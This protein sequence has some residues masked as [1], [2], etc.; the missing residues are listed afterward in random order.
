MRTE[1]LEYF[2]AITRL[3]SI[4]RASQ[5]LHVSQPALSETVR[6]LERELG[7][8][9]LDRHRAGAKISAAGR[10]LLPFITEALESVDRLREAADEQHRS[11]RMIRI[12][13]VSAATVPLLVPAVRDLHAAYPNTQIEI[14]N[15]QQ[16]DIQQWL[17]EG[18]LDVGLVNLIEGDDTDPDLDAT[19][20]LRGR[21]VLCCRTDSRFARLAAVTADD[22]R[23]EPL[24]VMRAGYVMHRYV[25]RLFGG[26]PPSIAY[27]ADGAEMGKLMVAEGLGVTLLPDYSV[28]GDPLE[29]AGVITSRPVEP[30]DVTVILVMQRRRDNRLAPAIRELQELLVSHVSKAALTGSPAA[31]MEPVRR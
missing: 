14:V 22:L 21:P 15:T 26:Q 23:E 30:A 17:R 1:Q 5:E 31:H 29:R 2:A 24:I 12:G 6:N 3:G 16:S 4:R 18:A 20:L 28:A 8:L 7:V 13:T 11:S 9:L 19:E 10:E 25:H 27:S